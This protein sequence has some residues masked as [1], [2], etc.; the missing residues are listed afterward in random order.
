MKLRQANLACEMEIVGVLARQIPTRLIEISQSGC[1]LESGLRIEEGTVGA[2]RLE[3][4]GHAYSEDVRA[5]RCVAIEGSGIELS[6]GRGVSADRT[7]RRG[8]DSPCDLERVERKS[9]GVVVNVERQKLRRECH[10]R[11]AA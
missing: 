9:P 6:G 11:N 1:L 7:R 2:L 8:V 5:T 10:A 3:V 4:R